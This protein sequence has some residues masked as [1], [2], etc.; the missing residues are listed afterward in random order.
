MRLPR[1]HPPLL[2]AASLLSCFFLSSSRA[3]N[4]AETVTQAR[5]SSNWHGREGLYFQKNWGIDIVGVRRLSSGYMLE[6]RYRV[7]DPDKAKPLLDKKAKA[8]LVDSVTRATL[9]VPA[10]ENVG[11]L[12]QAVEPEIGRTYYTIFG[13]PAKLVKKGGMVSVVIG[14]FR[15]DNLVV[16]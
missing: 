8:Y 6:F 1:I 4:A 3:G 14:N 16:E 11:E 12:R 13:N 9:A 7:L 15:V 2:L 10:M 5:P